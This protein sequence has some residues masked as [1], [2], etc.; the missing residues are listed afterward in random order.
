[1]TDSV[2]VSG[3]AAVRILPTDNQD[4]VCLMLS[5]T[6]GKETGFLINA[7]GLNALLLQALGLAIRWADSPDLQV[8]SWAG[9]KN[10]LPASHIELAKGR[11]STEV[12]LR[13]FVGKIELT[14][15]VPLDTVIHATSVLVQQIDPNSGRP[16]H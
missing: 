15:L 8:E 5:D 10:A 9:V 16:A 1:M 2:E 7:E 6:K 12:A 4:S 13:V 14:F 11:N 3:L